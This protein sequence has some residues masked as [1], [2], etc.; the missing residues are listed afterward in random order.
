MLAIPY[1]VFALLLVGVGKADNVAINFNNEIV[2]W[3]VLEDNTSFAITQEFTDA[4][5]SALRVAS[6][7]STLDAH[8]YSVPPHLMI[9]SNYWTQGTSAQVE[10]AVHDA[11]ETFVAW[12]VGGG[13]AITSDL[14]RLAVINIGRQPNLVNV[15]NSCQFWQ[16]SIIPPPPTACLR[17]LS[18]TFYTSNA[19]SDGLQTSLCQLLPTPCGLIT[20]TASSFDVTERLNL[21]TFDIA[22]GNRDSVLVTLVYYATHTSL[23]SANNIAYILVDGV[24]VYYQGDAPVLSY[25]G[26]SSE[27]MSHFWYLIFLIILAPVIVIVSYKCYVWGEISGRKK[28]MESEKDIRAGVHL[29]FMQWPRNAGIPGYLQGGVGQWMD[30]SA[31][32][33]RGYY[34]Q[35]SLYTQSSVQGGQQ[36]WGGGAVMQWPQSLQS[37]GR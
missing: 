26:T 24:Q 5:A 30:P 2:L 6:G 15:T 4:V 20:F 13:D 35:P 34:P 32:S 27:C 3:N 9:L 19:N 23:L 14:N 11:N 25:D 7:L 31:Q 22:A 28:V 1:L 21:M 29:T 12:S 16:Q 36:G 33:N 10:S 17:N 37:D 8:L 18:V